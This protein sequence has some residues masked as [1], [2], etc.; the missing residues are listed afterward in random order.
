[1]QECFQ[2]CHIP[3]KLYLKLKKCNTNQ[4]TEISNI[5]VIYYVCVN[6]HPHT[7]VNMEYRQADRRMYLLA[8]IKLL[9]GSLKDYIQF[10]LISTQYLS[11][12]AIFYHLYTSFFFFMFVLYHLPHR[13]L[14]ICIQLV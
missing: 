11:Y 5:F 8:A 2:A 3:F 10:N 12:F 7:H 1:M 4:M 6:T 9:Y 13:C 14:P